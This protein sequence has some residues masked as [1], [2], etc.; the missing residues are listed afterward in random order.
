MRDILTLSRINTL[1]PWEL[2][3]LVFSLDFGMRVCGSV[4]SG[5]MKSSRHVWIFVSTTCKNLRPSP[6]QG[7]QT[8]KC[9]TNTTVVLDVPIGL[10]TVFWSCKETLPVW[11]DEN[12]L[13][14]KL[15]SCCSCIRKL[16]SV[17]HQV[18]SCWASTP[19]WGFLVW[20]FNTG[21]IVYLCAAPRACIDLYKWVYSKYKWKLKSF[22]LKLDLFSF[23]RQNKPQFYWNV[24]RM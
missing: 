10:R 9:S 13:L 2:K 18:T 5:Y 24:Y 19:T 23:L 12:Q 8:E 1:C 20:M 17:V 16:V 21:L 22:L 3:S 4:F 6:G 11:C 15:F 14:L 7:N